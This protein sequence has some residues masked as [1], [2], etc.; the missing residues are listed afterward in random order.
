ML[1]WLD[2]LTGIAW[3]IAAV[4][5]PLAFNLYSQRVFEPEKAFVVRLVGLLLV[6]LLSVRIVIAPSSHY[7]TRLV[8]SWRQP[9]VYTSVPAICL[10]VAVL[11]AT[12]VSL[13]PSVSWSGS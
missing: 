10:T 13:A 6:V 4:F 9:R 1:R 3:L 2:R 8:S 12:L 7:R 11:V 5:I